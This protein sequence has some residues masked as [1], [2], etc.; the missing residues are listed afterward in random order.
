MRNFEPI[1]G[2]TKTISASSS[3]SSI[4][5]VPT[6]TDYMLTNAGAGTAFF[7]TGTTSATALVTD[8]PILAGAILTLRKPL[9]NYT[10]AAITATGTATVYVTPGNGQ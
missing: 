9:N 7:R 8:T 6:T 10:V 2:Q 4:T 1:E 3:S 5:L